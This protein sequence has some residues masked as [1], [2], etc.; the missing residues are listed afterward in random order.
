MKRALG[1]VRVST[2]LQ[3][4]EGVSLDNQKDRIRTYCQYRGFD[5]IGIVEDAGISGGKNKARPGFIEVLDRIESGEAQGLVLYSLERLSR[6]MLTLLALERLLDEH[7]IE[8][9]TVEGEVNTSTPDG[10]LNFAMKAFLGEMER[11]QV[12]YRTKRAMEFKKAQGSI[13]GSVPY[14]FRRLQD[15]LEP[16]EQEQVTIALAKSLYGASCGLSAI[17]RRLTEQG[18]MTRNGKP[19]TVEQVKRILPDYEKTFSHANTKLSQN[20]RGFIEA[21]A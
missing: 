5:L 16:D 13:V 21:I 14:G 10:W 8:L 15:R 12:K 2:S 3:A 18:H 20:I 7:D 6:D 4:S 9:H 1:Y 19:F 17:C 11:R